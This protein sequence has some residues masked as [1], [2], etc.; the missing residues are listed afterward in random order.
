MKKTLVL[1]VLFSSF[2]YGQFSF[3]KPY[4]IE[5]I[6]DIPFGPLI[7]ETDQ[8]RLGLE[9]QQ[10]SV[11]ILKYWLNEM[12]KNPFVSGDQKIN[13][14]LYDSQ[15][16]RRILIQVPVKGKTIEAFKTEAGFQDHYLDFIK[17]TYEWIL[18][19]F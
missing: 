1:L 6:S 15:K 19:N 9:G 14:I 13:F 2:S 5:V 12:R 7:S 8:L 10:W 4:Q 16:R 18:E 17:E 3:Y 11:E